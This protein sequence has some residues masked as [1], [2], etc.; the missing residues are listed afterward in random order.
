VFK[1]PAGYPMDEGEAR[2]AV[3]IAGDEVVSVGR[4]VHI[5]E[6]W[7]RDFRKRSSTTQVIQIVCVV[8]LV[9][10]YLA[11]AVFAVIRWSRHR[12]A[13]ATFAIFFG[14]LTVFGAVQILNGFR[15][16]TAQFV[17]AQPFKLQ[18][19]IV[20]IGGL[21]ATT[22][23]ASVSALLIGLAHRLFPPQPSPTRLRDGVVGFGIGALLAGLGAA[24]VRLAPSPLP[25]WPGFSG[26]A[27]SAPFLGAAL[28]PVS[29]WMTGTALLVLVVAVIHTVTNGWQRKQAGTAALLVLLGLVVTGSEGVESIPMWLLEGLLTGLVLLAVWV[30]ALRHHPALVPLVTAAGTVLGALRAAVIGAYP[31][32][33]AGSLISI[34]LVLGF[35]VWWFKRL[36]ADSGSQAEALER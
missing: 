17:T 18:V 31:G 34:V 13:S 9:L 14:L 24:G 4:Y 8:L 16:G 6:E 36:T 2:I 26:A 5:P 1:H 20:L 21:I 11:G 30:L 3:N 10:L 12:F 27:D 23:I 25:S 29:S 33:T 22:A 19:A 28:G 35:S 15:S 7:E 32:A